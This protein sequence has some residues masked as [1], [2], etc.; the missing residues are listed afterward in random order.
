MNVAEEY[1]K[2]QGGKELLNL[3]V[4]GKRTFK[5]KSVCSID[6]KNNQLSFSILAMSPG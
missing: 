2:R 4:I 5:V 3:I 6:L 1:K